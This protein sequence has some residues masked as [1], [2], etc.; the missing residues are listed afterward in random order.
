[1]SALP[2]TTTLHLNKRETTFL[3]PLTIIGLVAV[4]SI[5]ISLLFWRSGSAPGTTEWIQGSQANPGLAYALPGFLVYLGVQS[6]ATTFPFALTLGATRRAFVAGTLVWWMLTSA[7]L[8]VALALLTVLEILTNHWFVGFYVFDIYLL[9][10]GDLSLLLPIVFLGCWSL[11]TLGG[12]FGASWARY[13]ARGPQLIGVGIAI[14]LIVALIIIIPSAAKILAA[15]QLWWLAI[16][17]VVV[18]GLSSLGTWSLLR[19]ATVR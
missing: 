7:Y 11:L 15:F 17:A 1:M 14:L 3:V 13:G 5:L 9:G 19:T 18:I 4:I 6:I 2:A 16:A 12:V 10:S 8:A